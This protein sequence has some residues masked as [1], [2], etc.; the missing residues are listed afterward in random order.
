MAPAAPRS[1]ALRI[2]AS[3]VL[4]VDSRRQPW[5][6]PSRRASRWFIHSARPRHAMPACMYAANTIGAALGALAA[7]FVLLPAL[8]LTRRDLGRRAAQRGGRRAAPG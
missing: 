5:A 4:L 7:G 1:P 8:G 3:L 6:R 2:V